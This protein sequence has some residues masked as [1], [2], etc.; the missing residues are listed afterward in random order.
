[1]TD[2][3]NPLNIYVVWHPSFKE[4]S[5]YA[6]SFFSYYN[7]DIHDP[8]SR[9]IGIPVYFRTGDIPFEI[10]MDNSE[11]NV[12]VL[13]IT[14]E[15]IINDQWI[16]Y[17]DEIIERVNKTGNKS[18][19]LPIAV[20]ENAFN[21]PNKLPIQNFIRLYDVINKL[22]SL[23]SSTT[24]EMCRLLYNI[25]RINYKTLP[26][27]QTSPQPLKLFIS[28][29]KADGVDVAKSL[30]DYIQSK[31]ALKTFYDANDI[32]IGYDFT[33][34][35]EQNIQKSVLLVIHSDKYS[36]R[37]WCRREILIAKKNNR[38]IVIVN[39]YEEGEKRS[40]PY[41]AN[42]KTIRFNKSIQETA[43]FNKIILLTLKETLRYKYHQ[44]FTIYLTRKFSISIAQEAILS[45]PPELLSLIYLSGKSNSLSIYPDPPL[46]EEELDL[47]GQLSKEDIQF[48]TP[49]LIPLIRKVEEYDI[50]ELSFLDDLKIGI[51]ISESQNIKSYGF[52]HIHLKDALVVL[53]TH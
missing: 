12:V 52:E 20:S 22:E 3:I 26:N 25:D 7:H 42:L 33:Q 48:I 8:L 31:T 41:M 24:H 21:L 45:Q 32:A 44:I 13:L 40:F 23:I 46:S 4:G 1:M 47:I 5:E 35:I 43:M 39:L 27:V 6:E 37:E 17:I 53:L 2:I 15:M 14:D 19:I 51:S 30:N 16:R 28:H 50:H 11:Y 38:P 34:E 9:G 18:I 49:T 10:N 29:A 36:S